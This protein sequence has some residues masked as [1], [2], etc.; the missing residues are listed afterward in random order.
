MT[1]VSI[2]EWRRH[3]GFGIKN[4]KQSII[5]FKI[6]VVNCAFYIKFLFIYYLFIL[7]RFGDL[8]YNELI[9]DLLSLEKFYGGVE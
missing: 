7:L 6:L 3:F 9:T 4:K 5:E 1:F 2:T 8:C